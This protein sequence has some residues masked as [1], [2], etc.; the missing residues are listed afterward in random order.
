MVVLHISQINAI[1][2]YE[3]LG[4]ALVITNMPLVFSNDAR[5]IQI[6]TK[7]RGDYRA[8]YSVL[9]RLKMLGFDPGSLCE[10]PGSDWNKSRVLK[11][12]LTWT[13]ISH[14]FVNF[15]TFVLPLPTISNPCFRVFCFLM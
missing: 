5:I 13:L 6:E 10:C 3:K 11:L 9:G 8:T 15:Y 2:Y 12:P 14:F 4:N 1:E 7:N